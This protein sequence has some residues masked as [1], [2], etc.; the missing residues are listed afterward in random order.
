MPLQLPCFNHSSAHVEILPRDFQ[1]DLPALRLTRLGLGYV[2]R[3]QI[4]NLRAHFSEQSRFPFKQGLHFLTLLQAGN[5]ISILLQQT[6][7]FQS[8]T[9]PQHYLAAAEILDLEIPLPDHSFLSLYPSNHP[10]ILSKNP[11]PSSPILTWLH[12]LSCSI[13]MIPRS[14]AS[15]PIAISSFPRQTIVVLYLLEWLPTLEEFIKSVPLLLP[16]GSQA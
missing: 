13:W 9:R 4:D 11:V 12:F 7:Q 5:W 10:Q 14:N 2:S 8:H 3:L 6:P 15:H 16:S 1:C